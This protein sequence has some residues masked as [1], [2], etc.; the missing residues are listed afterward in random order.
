VEFRDKLK[1]GSNPLGG[2]IGGPARTAKARMMAEIQE[3]SKL[4][5]STKP[6]DDVEGL[7]IEVKWEPTKGTL[8][9]NLSS[10]ESK[11][12][13]EFLKIVRRNFHI[14]FYAQ[15]IL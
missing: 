4:G 14:D 10:E 15:F 2:V 9:V 12:T 3:K 5:V 8:G 6:S 1:P 13:S 7:K 11:L